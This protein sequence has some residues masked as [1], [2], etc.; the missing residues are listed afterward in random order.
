MELRSVSKAQALN[1]EIKLNIE[2]L[3]LEVFD[4]RKPPLLKQQDIY[5]GAYFLWKKVWLDTFKELEGQ[6]QIFSDDFY[7]QNEAYA[8]FYQ[9]D[10]VGIT[11][12]SFLDLKNPVHRDLKYF[13][14]YPEGS[15]EAIENINVRHVLIS[16]QTAVDSKYRKT[17]TG[18][19]FGDVLIGLTVK[20]LMHSQCDAF[21]AY[22]N[23]SKKVQEICYR[24][25]AQPIVKGH[26]QH[27]VEVD[28]VCIKK[29][30]ASQSSLTEVNQLIDFLWDKQ[31]RQIPLNNLYSLKTG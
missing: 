7:R 13:K 1:N 25:G 9:N 27:N 30:S 17:Y 16:N 21:I 4:P 12:H 15:I 26:S 28:I 20:R 14:A 19:A 8:I 3:R 31:L 11:M 24:F 6:N 29:D 23:N 22:T 10:C 2:D 18:I 5:Y